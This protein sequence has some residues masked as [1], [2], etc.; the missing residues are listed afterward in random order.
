VI[1]QENE[2]RIL[3]HPVEVYRFLRDQCAACFIQFIMI[4][5]RLHENG[6]PFGDA[7]LLAEAR[8][9]DAR[10]VPIDARK[11]ANGVGADPSSPP[12]TG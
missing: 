10:A 9:A 11:V 4:A 6:V 2:V 12:R 7:A 1:E 3:D 5:A 8:H